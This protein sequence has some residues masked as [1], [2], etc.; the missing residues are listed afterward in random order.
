MGR[1]MPR[2]LLGGSVT[3]STFT[4]FSVNSAKNPCC[5]RSGITMA[6][7]AVPPPL[8][9]T[10]RPFPGRHGL[11]LP[12]LPLQVFFHKHSFAGEGIDAGVVHQA[13]IG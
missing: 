9:D 4:A 6:A 12:G 10:A 11:F 8:R 2:S 3:L 5:P 7:V 1:E 13:R